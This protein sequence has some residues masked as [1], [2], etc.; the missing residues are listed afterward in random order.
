MPRCRNPELLR[1][2]LEQHRP[3]TESLYNLAFGTA[4]GKARWLCVDHLPRPRAVL[5]S[6][7]R[8]CLFATDTDAA[9]R[10][11]AE[12]PRN[13]RMQFRATPGRFIPLVRRLWHG[14]DRS[15][16]VWTNPC[17]Q[18]ALLDPGRLQVCTG[19]RISR[20]TL[21]DADTVV[22]HSPYNRRA[23]YVRARILAGPSC[24]IRRRNELVAWG[25]THDDGSMGFLYVLPEYRGKG[26]ARALTTALARKLLRRNIRPFMYIVRDNRASVSL[27]SSMGFERCG[28]L[29]WFGTR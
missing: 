17:C 18:F 8:L 22:R 4:G 24:G 27:T 1:P 28:T 11:L 15:S 23:D 13:Q 19:P 26:L 29:Y 10:V 12:V 21:A 9:S 14:P 5:L 7:R 2:L 6:G 16:E 20:L 3:L 25:L